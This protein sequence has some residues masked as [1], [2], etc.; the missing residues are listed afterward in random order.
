V[1]VETY[2]AKTFSARRYDIWTMQSAY[3]NLPTINGFPQKDGRDHAASDVRYRAGARAAELSLDIAGAYPP[4]AGVKA[5][6]RTL[7]LERGRRIVVRDR[8][9]LDMAAAPAVWTF[10]TVRKPSEAGPGRI[11]LGAADSPGRTEPL[12]LIYDGARWRAAIEPIAVN[13]TR[14]RAAWGGTVYRILLRAKAVSASGEAVF[15]VE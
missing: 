9:E 12:R 1:G 8:Y 11:L 15:R 4:E 5:W 2:T 14:L 10:M 7:R 13:D 3:H 6:R